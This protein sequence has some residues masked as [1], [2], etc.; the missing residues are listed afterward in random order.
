[1]DELRGLRAL[2]TGGSSGIGAAIARELASHGVT[3]VLTARREQALRDVAASCTGAK[4]EIIVGD[5][6]APG[7]A[8]AVW[9]RATAGGPVDILINNAG[10]GA[11]G[12]FAETEL[13]RDAEMVQL[14]MASLVELS[15][16][17]VAQQR[18]RGY[19]LNI[20]S[21]GA[22]QAVPNMAL[23]A[24]SKAF[25]RDFTEALHDELAGGPVSATC[26]CPGGIHTDF[27]AVAGAGNYGWIARLSMMDAPALARISVRAMAKRKR[28]IIPGFLNK[29]SCW[30]VRLVPRSLASWIAGKVMGKPPAAK[31]KELAA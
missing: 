16:R 30:S 26:V 18:P 28:N 13:A 4:T 3:L 20:A 12:K 22:Y 14:N 19:V 5:L 24:A 25:V 2:V 6:G 1:M 10:F 11:L 23:Y 21:I 31:K 8:Q 7:G 17:F 27:H 29:L 9:T 15:Q